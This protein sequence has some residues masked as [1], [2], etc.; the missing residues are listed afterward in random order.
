MVGGLPSPIS[1]P[2]R[3]RALACLWG[4]PP[5]YRHQRKGIPPF[6]ESSLDRPHLVLTFAHSYDRAAGA[7]ELRRQPETPSYLDHLQVPGADCSVAVYPPTEVEVPIHQLAQC[8]PVASQ[9]SLSALVREPR[10][11]LHGLDDNG[12]PIRKPV[13]H[14]IVSLP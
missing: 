8:A 3:H 9:Q 7:R 10:K 14:R 1:I 11:L 12:I 6:P 5:R 13:P 2:T 4:L